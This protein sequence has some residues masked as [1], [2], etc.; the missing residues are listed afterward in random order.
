MYSSSSDSESETVCMK[1]NQSKLGFLSDSDSD[2]A[3]RKANNSKL[4]C[5]S[6]LQSDDELF[7]G[8]DDKCWRQR[9]QKWEK[10]LTNWSH[11]IK[12]V[13]LFIIYLKILSTVSL[14]LVFKSSRVSSDISDISGD[15]HPH[16]HHQL[17]IRI[18]LMMGVGGPQGWW[19]WWSKVNVPHD[20]LQH[21]CGDPSV[22]HIII[23][24]ICR[25]SRW[26]C[27]RGGEL[28]D[29]EEQTAEL[30]GSSCRMRGSRKQVQN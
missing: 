26:F 1:P 17:L 2:T 14:V 7:P 27:F 5:S 10:Q 25:S 29:Q 15:H 8:S 9:K 24:I 11:K 4:A 20:H 16:P 12:L 22:N 13:Y 30:G 6:A 3:V 19:S 21:R 23:I 18:L 28:P